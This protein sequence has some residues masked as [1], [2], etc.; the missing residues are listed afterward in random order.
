MKTC[1]ICG[2]EVKDEITEC[3]ICGAPLGDKKEEEKED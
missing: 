1:P 2:A 3:P